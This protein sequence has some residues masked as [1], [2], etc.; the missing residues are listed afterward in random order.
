MSGKLQLNQE[1][2]A[3]LM[4]AALGSLTV[5]L[6]W[7]YPLGSAM[8][9]GPGYLPR[10]IGLLLIVLGLGM[11][12]RGYLRGGG[13]IEGWR[14]RPIFFVILS[15]VVFAFVIEKAGLVI[16]S[17]ASFLIGSYGGREFRLWEQL[18]LGTALSLAVA[19]LF[20]VGLGLPLQ[21]WPS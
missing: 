21:L 4:F 12:G 13:A 7:S 20:V 15:F 6:A 17:L 8:R 1:T 3:G 14:F 2:V 19:A 18:L 11:A 10:I 9:M 5:T 16:A